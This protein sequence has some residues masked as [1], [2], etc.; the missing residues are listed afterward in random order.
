MTDFVILDDSLRA[1]AYSPI[2]WYCKHKKPT[3]KHT[4][5]AFQDHI[6]DEIWNG[7]NDHTQPYPGDQGIQFERRQPKP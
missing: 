7:E 3:F 6:P 5:S 1:R 4:C 2:C